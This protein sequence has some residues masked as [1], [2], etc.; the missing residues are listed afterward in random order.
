MAWMQYT[1][2]IVF[3][4]ILG[5]FSD[6]FVVRACFLSSGIL[7]VRKFTSVGNLCSCDL[8]FQGVVGFIVRSRE[9]VRRD[10][11]SFWGSLGDHTACFGMFEQLPQGP[12]VLPGFTLSLG[13][14]DAS[15][16]EIFLPVVSEAT[17]EEGGNPG[18]PVDGFEAPGESSN[19]PEV[20]DVDCEC[21]Q[22]LQSE[23][24]H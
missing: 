8:R 3:I 5:C 6:Q 4:A 17:E 10:V 19:E 11:I 15:V 24:E 1:P 7:Y 23:V 20:L 14:D 21:Y 16:V 13:D 9:F 2:P 12:G 18:S 22:E